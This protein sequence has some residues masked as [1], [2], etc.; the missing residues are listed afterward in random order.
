M[1]KKTDEELSNKSLFEL[2]HF[3][4]DDISYETPEKLLEG[5]AQFFK[6]AELNPIQ[7]EKAFGGRNGIQKTDVKI[8]RAL[9]IEGLTVFL[10][11]SHRTFN[12]WTRPASNNYRPDLAPVV[13]RIK[14]FIREQ[15]FTG[16][17]AGVFNPMIIARD[18]QLRE[19]TEITGVDGGPIETLNTEM[20]LEEKA[21]L[22]RQNIKEEK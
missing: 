16:A 7:S 12:D 8:L 4:G 15:K 5:C 14:Q 21:A 6:W 2:G 11:I 19:Q 13:V 22:F 10:G 1:S 18:L 9:T 20:S 3:L 17:A